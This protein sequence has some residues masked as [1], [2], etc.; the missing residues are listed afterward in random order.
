METGQLECM[1]KIIEGN[2]YR[3]GWPNIS[4]AKLTDTFGCM[5][6]LK[7]YSYTFKNLWNKNVTFH[8]ELIGREF[9][10]LNWFKI[11]KI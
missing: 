4:R 8:L 6:G 10:F 11:M 9:E 7:I 2:G 3:G 5:D 1:P